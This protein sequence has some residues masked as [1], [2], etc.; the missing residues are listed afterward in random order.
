MALS[1]S[2]FV[3]VDK[4]EGPQKTNRTA[5]VG[6]PHLCRTIFLFLDCQWH[7]PAIHLKHGQYHSHQSAYDH[8]G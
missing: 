8:P 1:H 7:L 6:L 2:S 3:D 4:N 5:L